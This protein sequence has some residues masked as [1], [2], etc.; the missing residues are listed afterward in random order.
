MSL[1]RYLGGSLPFDSRIGYPH[2]HLLNYDPFFSDTSDYSFS[3]KVEV[4]R[5]EDETVVQAE[6]AGFNKNDIHVNVSDDCR[7][8]VISGE[9]KRDKSYQEGTV[10][11]SERSYGSFT[12]SFNIPI[13]SKTDDI[14]AS[15]NNGLLYVKVP[16]DVNKEHQQHTIAIE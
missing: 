2:H 13:D 7:R 9:S 14:K 12:R 16:R 3:P 10:S 1:S 4:I 11:Y 15:F 8:L 5:K 6:L